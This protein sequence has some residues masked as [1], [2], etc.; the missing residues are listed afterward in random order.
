MFAFDDALYMDNYFL[1]EELLNMSLLNP[2]GCPISHTYFVNSTIE[3]DIIHALYK[4]GHEI[5]SHSINHPLPDHGIYDDLVREMVGMKNIIVHNASI[6]AQ[7][8]R[9]L[10]MPH[11][12]MG[13]NAQFEM[14]QDYDFLYDATFIMSMDLP[15]GSVWPYTLDTPPGRLFCSQSN[16]PNHSF[17]GI[18]EIPMTRTHG[19]NENICPMMDSAECQGNTK[20]DT[21]AYL[22]KNFQ[23]IVS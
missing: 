19:L 22:W 1:H 3:P 20:S 14:M 23:S 5:G 8:I 18:W 9:G 10:R 6:P 17:P 4:K 11:L 16:C 7:E 15:H 2:N 13:E 12:R 21:L